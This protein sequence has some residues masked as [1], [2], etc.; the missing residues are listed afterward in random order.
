[1]RQ[2]IK[3][4]KTSNPKPQRNAYAD[5]DEGRAQYRTAKSAWHS[6]LRTQRK[7]LN[8]LSE[9]KI[10]QA[11]D[12]AGK[13]VLHAAVLAVPGEARRDVAIEEVLKAIDRALTF[14]PTILGKIAE[15]GTD[16]FIY[17]P[18]R[19]RVERAVDGAYARLKIASL[20]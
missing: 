18:L 7:E 5:G 16:W 13:A 1:M 14:P 12:D 3:D 2:E 6:Q 20:V 17:H 15:M 9:N 10:R 11:L 19:N 8:T 4:W